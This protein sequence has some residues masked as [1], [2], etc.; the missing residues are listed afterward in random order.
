MS[1]AAAG[2]LGRRRPEDTAA[3]TGPGRSRRYPAR[4]AVFFEGH[5]CVG[6][7]RARDRGPRVGAVGQMALVSSSKAAATRR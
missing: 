2:F 5:C 1:A 4:S 7:D 6:G 3:L